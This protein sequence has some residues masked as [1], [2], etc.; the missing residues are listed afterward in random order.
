MKKALIC[1]ALF[2]SLSAPSK[3]ATHLQELKL[4]FP[5]GLLTDDYGVL[6]K[7][8]LMINTCIAKPTPFS[9]TDTISPYP[10]WQCFEVENSAMNCERGRYD[11]HEKAVM[12]MLVVVGERDAERHEFI[13]RRPIS[14][15]SCELY[16]KDWQKLTQNERYV[17]V[18]GSDHSMVIQNGKPVGNWIFGRYKTNKG[19]D[20]YFVDECTSTS[21]CET[22]ATKIE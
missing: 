5:F 3:A 18:S 20:S 22:S 13:S 11:P 8:D 10:Y 12:S 19:C 1:L 6:N 17:C 14:L 2:F 4:S 16:Q 15:R 21:I 9:S 7:M